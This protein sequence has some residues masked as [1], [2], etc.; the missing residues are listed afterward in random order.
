[1]ATDKPSFILYQDLIYT[2][3]KV[4]DSTAGKLFKHILEY[5]NDRNPD[6]DDILISVLFEPIKQQLKRDLRK[7]ESRR[8]KNRENALKRWNNDQQNTMQEDAIASNGINRNAKHAVNGNVND[9]VNVN[10]NDINNSPKSP[11]GDLTENEVKF[12]EWFNLTLEKHKGVKGRFKTL[13]KIDKGNL[14]K[15]KA[16]YDN[17]NDWEVA[18]KQMTLN[19]WVIENNKCTV[20]HFLR[21]DNFMKYLNEGI[22]TEQPKKFK[23]PWQ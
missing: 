13:T 22:Q 16:S 19:P 14:K 18:F 9:T 7:Y 6:P 3:E 21:L 12:L 23:A 8:E 1:M 15:L 4:D 11:K 2:I 10:V 5:V 17:F 20:D